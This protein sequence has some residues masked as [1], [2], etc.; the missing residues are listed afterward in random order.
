[1]HRKFL[2]LDFTARKRNIFSRP[3]LSHFAILQK[4]FA[5]LPQ[6]LRK[7][8][9]DCTSCNACCNKNVARLDDCDVT[10]CNFACN[11]CHNDTTNL[12]DK[13]HNVTAPYQ[14]LSFFNTAIT[15]IQGK[16]EV[17]LPV[18]K[19][20]IIISEWMRY[21]LFRESMLNSVVFAQDK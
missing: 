20:D 21:C 5:T 12:R 9:A 16:I 4:C 11:L 1:M 2:F 15:L 3:G 8:E 10:P 18:E 14:T 7:A 17:T 13:L 19:V 6:S